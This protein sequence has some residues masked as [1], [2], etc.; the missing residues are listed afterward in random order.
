MVI[1]VATANDTL[2]EHVLL[3]A[4]DFGERF[5]EDLRV[6]RLVEDDAAR[7]DVKYHRDQLTE[8][9]DG[10]DASA[11]VSIE[12]VGHSIGR[13][14]ARI[15][16]ELVD[17]AAEVDVTHIVIGHAS[18]DFAETLVHGD[19]AFAVADNAS[20]PVTVVPDDVEWSSPET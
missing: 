4:R 6:V 3:V 13:K 12:H 5:D 8:R 15:G 7:I 10:L 1:L 18:K 9:L 20:V 19:T 16:K 17:L 2:Q 11:T 14:S